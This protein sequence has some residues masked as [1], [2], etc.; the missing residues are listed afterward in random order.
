MPLDDQKSPAMPQWAQTREQNTDLALA[1]VSADADVY[2]AVQAYANALADAPHDPA[3]LPAWLRAFPQFGEELRAVSWHTWTRETDRRSAGEADEAEEDPVIVGMGRSVLAS[4][5][6][7]AS[8]APPLTSLLQ[9]AQAQ[10]LSAGEFAR[11]VRLDVFLLA[12]LEQRLIRAASL[13]RAL[14]EQIAHTLDRSAADVA[15]YLRGRP[16]FAAGAHYKA[17]QAPQV[18]AP[19]DFSVALAASSPDTRA[20]WQ[21]SQDLLGDNDNADAKAAQ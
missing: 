18:G 4:L 14:V 1:A 9:A 3:L 15:L 8:S 10:G 2:D 5:F 16:S 19:V 11:A 17:R 12:R 6:P 21:G 13:P 7:L 20:A